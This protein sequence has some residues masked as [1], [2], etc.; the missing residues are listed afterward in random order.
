MKDAADFATQF[1]EAKR[2]RRLLIGGT[3]DNVGMFRNLLPKSLQSLIIG[4]F[5]ISMTASTA[6]VLDKALEAGRKAEAHRESKLVEGLIDAAAKGGNAVTGLADTLTAVN[7]NRVQT[8]VIADGF[9]KSGY[10]CPS[11]E[12]LMMTPNGG[13][14]GCAGEP[15]RIYDVVEVAITNV[16]RR[17]GTVEVVHVNGQFEEAGNI[18]AVLRY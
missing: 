16:L 3:E 8:L 11:C 10:Y 7:D 1:F 13:C 12:R 2:V 9:R 17:K 5:P 6:E 4:S 15:E 14:E 18:G